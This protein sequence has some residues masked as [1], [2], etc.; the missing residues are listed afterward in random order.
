M[1]IIIVICDQLQ[2]IYDYEVHVR[3]E[4]WNSDL[5]I[6]RQYHFRLINSLTLPTIEAHHCKKTG[7]SYQEVGMKFTGNLS[8]HIS[9]RKL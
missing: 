2:D 5:V 1:L 6:Y 7:I 4:S 3:G 8:I 9:S